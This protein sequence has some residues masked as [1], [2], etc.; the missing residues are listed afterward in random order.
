MAFVRAEPRNLIVEEDGTG[1]LQFGT[2]ETDV[3]YE[4]ETVGGIERL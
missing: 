3:N 2:V 1:L 4:V